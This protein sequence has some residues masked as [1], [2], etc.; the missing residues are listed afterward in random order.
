MTSRLTRL[1]FIPLVPKAFNTW[2]AVPEGY[3]IPHVEGTPLWI[4]R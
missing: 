1:V 2:D 3:P 4:G